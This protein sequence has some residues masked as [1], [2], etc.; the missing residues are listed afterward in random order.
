MLTLIYTIVSFL[1]AL[2]TLINILVWVGYVVVVSLIVKYLYTNK[3]PTTARPITSAVIGTCIG[4]FF[5]Y[6][7]GFHT[8]MFGVLGVIL[9]VLGTI[10]FIRIYNG[11]RHH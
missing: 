2:V 11:Q 9:A 8:S 3:N 5:N 7:L 6:T 1:T 4:A 10:L